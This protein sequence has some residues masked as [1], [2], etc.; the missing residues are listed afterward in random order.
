MP[1]MLEGC[2]AEAGGAVS[3][4]WT[5]E[6]EEAQASVPD[7]LAKIDRVIAAVKAYSLEQP[8][9]M[10]FHVRP[11]VLDKLLQMWHREWK[12]QW[13]EQRRTFVGSKEEWWDMKGVRKEWR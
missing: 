4:Q 6:F 3:E 11:S 2:C 1:R 8:K 5:K 12:R 7:I 10:V 9:E 13:R